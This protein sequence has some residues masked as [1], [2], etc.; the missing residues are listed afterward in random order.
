MGRDGVTL[1][2]WCQNILYQHATISWLLRLRKWAEKM[3]GQTHL[4]IFMKLQ[5][6]SRIGVRHAF[7]DFPWH[8]LGQP[9]NEENCGHFDGRSS[10]AMEHHQRSDGNFSENVA[11]H[12]SDISTPS[13][14]PVSPTCQKHSGLGILEL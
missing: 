8:K 3:L 10:C 9:L 1:R 11:E 5:E 4:S 12:L 7:Q 2:S 13:R 6:A 14:Q